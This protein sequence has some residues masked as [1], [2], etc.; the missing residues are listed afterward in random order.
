LAKGKKVSL[1]AW[2]HYIKM[3]K[4]E[5]DIVKALGFPRAEKK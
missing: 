5:E 2:D 1:V 4:Y 3:S